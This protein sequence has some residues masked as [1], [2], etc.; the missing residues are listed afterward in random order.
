ML[1]TQD[2]FARPAD[3]IGAELEAEYAVSK[4]EARAQAGHSRPSGPRGKRLGP[5]A[6][7]LL[8]VV[9]CMLL[10]RP[11]VQVALEFGIEYDYASEDT[12]DSSSDDEGS[13]DGG[14]ENEEED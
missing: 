13:E 8:V 7:A 5:F 12:S 4:K 2:D 6:A 11:L 10:L 9:A 14:S 3:L 1:H